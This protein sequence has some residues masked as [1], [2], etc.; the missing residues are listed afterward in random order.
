MYDMKFILNV[1]NFGEY[2]PQKNGFYCLLSYDV[3]LFSKS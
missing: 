2:P 1:R 3:I